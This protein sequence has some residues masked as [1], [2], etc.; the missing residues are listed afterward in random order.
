[1][2][3]FISEFLKIILIAG[4]VSSPVWA[5][6]IIP[7]GSITTVKIAAQ[8]VTQA[9]LAPRAEVTPSPSMTPSAAGSVA[10]SSSSGTFSTTSASLVIVTN[11]Q[12]GLTTTG[13]PVVVELMGDIGGGG[14]GGG[15]AGFIGVG[16]S[17][18]CAFE[19]FSGTNAIGIQLLSVTGSFP[20]GSL[21][22]IDYP[23]AGNQIY[24]VKV[25]NSIGSGGCGI[26]Y[27]DLV[28]HEL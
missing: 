9:K 8:A 24:S 11:L 4:L 28:A 15:G 17:T 16:T 2:N 6:Y 26:Q 7:S 13:R 21:R 19:I 18:T 5:S 1:M 12:V 14:G 23:A 25:E 27:S 10:V 3:K 22:A 20:S